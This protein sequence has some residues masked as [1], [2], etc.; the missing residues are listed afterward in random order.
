MKGVWSSASYRPRWQLLRRL[1]P[2]ALQHHMLNL[3]LQAPSLIL[4]VLVT[5]LLS[6]KA[7]AWFYVSWMLGG[8]GTVF[9][10]VLAT[11]LYATT[12]VQPEV[13]TQKV[14]LTLSMAIAASILVNCVIFIGARQLLWLFGS[15]YA[16]HAEWSLRILAL[17]TIPRVIKDHY[18]A[19]CRIQG[20][21]I[22]AVLPMAIGGVLELG[23]AALGAHYGG[24]TGLSLGWACAICAE[25]AFGFYTVYRA[26]LPEAVLLRIKHSLKV[27]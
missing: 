25:A 20:R 27:R 14:R 5:V 8:L 6:A 21:V 23:M 10:S 2:A 4:P 7:N 19:I 18:I 13:L 16:Q 17:A 12:S 11:V 15:S 24:L 3:T 26:V 1:G 22:H 9:P